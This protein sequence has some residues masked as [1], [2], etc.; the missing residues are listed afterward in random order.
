M[1]IIIIIII[2]NNNNSNDDEQYKWNLENHSTC[3]SP[4]TISTVIKVTSSPVTPMP[5]G[6]S[7]WKAWKLDEKIIIISKHQ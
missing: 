1:V 3:S 6:N 4:H 5:R 7:G 2:F